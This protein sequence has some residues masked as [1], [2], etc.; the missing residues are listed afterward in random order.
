MEALS[1]LS[2][3]AAD[4]QAGYLT[5][6]CILEAE[7]LQAR[8]FIKMDCHHAALNIL[9]NIL[10]SVSSYIYDIKSLFSRY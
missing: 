2:H 10:I 7:L 8:I 4:K 6:E 1:V 3:L 5:D 9:D